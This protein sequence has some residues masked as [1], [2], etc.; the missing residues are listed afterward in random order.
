MSKMNNQSDLNNLSDLSSDSDLDLDSTFSSESESASGSDSD[1]ETESES[2][3]E[4]ET[5][6]ETDSELYLSSDLSS[7]NEIVRNN[8]KSNNV[9]TYDEHLSE[10]WFSLILLGLKTVEGRKNKG[11]FR[12][13][14]INDIINFS[15]SDIIPRSVRTKIVSKN[16]YLTFAAYLETEGLEKCL[17]GISTLDEGLAIY[18]KYYTKE[19][20]ANYGVVAIGLELC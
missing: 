18:Y 15:N 3:S 11:R 14:K 2:E 1:S 19:D 12:E 20:E 10:P 17:P 6:S 9:K 8:P 16:I 5:D 13:M 7:D 4:S